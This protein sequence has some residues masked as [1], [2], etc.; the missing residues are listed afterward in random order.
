MIIIISLLFVNLSHQ[1]TLMVFSLKFKWQQ[2]FFL[3][4]ILA[5]WRLKYQHS[6]FSCHFCLPFLLIFFCAFSVTNIFLFFFFFV[7]ESPYYFSSVLLSNP[8]NFDNNGIW[9]VSNRPLIST[10]SSFLTKAFDLVPRA[11][12]TTG[13]TVTLMFH[14]FYCCLARSMYLSIFFYFHSVDSRDG[15]LH[16]AEGSVFWLTITRSSLL[17]GSRWSSRI[18]KS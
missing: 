7:F 12:I 18:S 15:R 4:G 17:A 6:C 10:S 13:I 2:V 3:C 8:I 14:G 11:P 1:L 9:I 5:V 16:C